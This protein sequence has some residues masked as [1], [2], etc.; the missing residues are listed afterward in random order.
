MKKYI[1]IALFIIT[2]FTLDIKDAEAFTTSGSYQ[3][4]IVC[5]KYCSGA[6][7]D[8]EI[9]GLTGIIAGSAYKFVDLVRSNGNYV[10]R[11][12]NLNIG[13]TVSL[14]TSQTSGWWFFTGGWDD[15]P[16]SDGVMYRLELEGA[17]RGFDV[18]ISMPNE[19]TS[20]PRIRSSNTNIVSC[21]NTGCTAQKPGTAQITV[22]FPPTVQ[23]SSYPFSK[24][25]AGVG[26]PMGYGKVNTRIQDLYPNSAGILSARKDSNG[27]TLGTYRVASSYELGSIVYN[28]TVPPIP[29][30]PHVV[31]CTGISNI[32]KYGATANWSYSDIDGDLQ[33][34]Y[35]VQV[36]TD[37]SFVNIVQSRT[38]TANTD[39]SAVRST[40]LSGLTSNTKYYVRVRAYNNTNAWSAYSSCGLGF[41]TATDTTTAPTCFC[42]KRDQVCSYSYSTSTEKNAPICNF[43]SAC[44]VTSGQNDV[45]FTVIPIN[46]LGNVN[47]KHG[48][49]SADRGSGVAY[50][51]TT[52]KT[53]GTQSVNFS[54]TDTYDNK[55][56]SSMCY[57]ENPVTGTPPE[58]IPISN[59]TAINGQCNNSV[60]YSCSAGRY[61]AD[62]NISPD[63]WV[64]HGINGGSEASCLYDGPTTPTTPIINLTK[65]PKVTLNRGGKCTLSWDI[66][67]VPTPDGVCMLT[68]WN[69]GGSGQDI[70]NTKN[71]TI[72]SGLQTNQK[73]VL[74]CTGLGQPTPTISKSVICRVNPNISEN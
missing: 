13:K 11:N 12:F 7:V 35:V 30:A 43:S 33:S 55:T 71:S 38:A 50:V 73:Y 64:C 34:N 32:S 21:T 68:G 9:N 14:D 17:G 6:N 66:Q 53:S 62:R 51:Y 4:K 72:I 23:T 48:D 25:P 40:V 36:S 61:I 45:T 49:I 19:G 3:I 10:N 20:I 56:S 24:N 67:N 22:S 63:T 69:I 42:D 41:T 70:K 57:I 5:L 15:S 28:V 1:H 27:R 2:F 74:T 47:Y 16:P 59:P 39:V 31:T 52:P 44:T 29:N 37:P 58:V 46:S 18:G 8:L 60:R 65:D 26:D 54:L